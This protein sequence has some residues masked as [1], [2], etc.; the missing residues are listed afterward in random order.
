MPHVESKKRGDP[1]FFDHVSEHLNGHHLPPAL[2]LRTVVQNVVRCHT[3][4]P[5][6]PHMKTEIVHM[7]EQKKTPDLSL[8]ET[9]KTIYQTCKGPTHS[10]K[11]TEN[12]SLKCGQVSWHHV[13]LRGLRPGNQHLAQ[14]IDPRHLGCFGKR[15]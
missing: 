3:E 12:L 5:I 4:L 15:I 1:M 2:R 10:R 6:H 7:N 8:L 13:T 14:S 9:R 11:G